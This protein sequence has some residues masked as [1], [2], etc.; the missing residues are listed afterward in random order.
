VTLLVVGEALVDVL[1]GVDH[2][3]GGPANIAVG[4]GRLGHDVALLTC[5]G[6]DD[7]G[8]LVRA[9]L[10]ASDVDVLAAPLPRTSTARATLDAAGVATYEFDITWDLGDLAPATA[11]TWLHVGS[12]GATLQPGADQ[13]SRLVSRYGGSTVISYDPNVRPLLMSEADSPRILDLASRAHVVKLSEEDGA[14]LHPGERPVD[15]ALRLLAL[16]PQLVVVTLG[17]NGAL[18]VLRND[19]TVV[20]AAPTA[21]GPV[22]DTV[23]AGDAFMAGL[24]DVLSGVDIHSLD[25]GLVRAALDR[26]GLVA[27]RTC[28]RVGADPPRRGELQGV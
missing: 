22:V 18:A 28:E 14:W 19:P 21:G 24:V 8:R 5:L 17:A 26:A 16:G 11:P 10:E 2:P 12:L 23:G 25:V 6:D 7:R 27:R 1:E 13:V 4:L 3:G 15:V 20:L 9:H